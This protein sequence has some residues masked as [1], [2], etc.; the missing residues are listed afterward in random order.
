MLF[1]VLITVLAYRAVSRL[2]AVTDSQTQILQAN[3][4][5]A[6]VSSRGESFYAVGDTAIYH[7]VIAQLDSALGLTES[8]VQNLRALSVAPELGAQVLDTM[9]ALRVCY[10]EAKAKR[11]VVE[12]YRAQMF[13]SI[14]RCRAQ[15]MSRRKMARCGL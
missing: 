11:E 9:R 6:E 15:A 2:N 8:S 3:A 10:Q 4:H 12:G 5:M 13:A 1:I 14:A 7:S